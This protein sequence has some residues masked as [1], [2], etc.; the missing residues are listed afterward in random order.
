M[1]EPTT[2]E[3]AGWLGTPVDDCSGKPLG[4]VSGIY[5][6]AESDDPK[7]LVVRL[8][9]FA[10]EAAIPFADTAEGGGRVWVA[11]A[12]QEV[13]SSHRLKGGRALTA[14]QELELCEHYGIRTGI[15]RAAEVAQRDGEQVS[16]VPGAA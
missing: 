15:G 16:A 6:D 7:W 10:G 12:R 2:E 14:G 5:A 9:P 1:A 4:K 3:A 13:R 11:Y 8:G